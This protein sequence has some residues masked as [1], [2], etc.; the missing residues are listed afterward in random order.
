MWAEDIVSRAA[1]VTVFSRSQPWRHPLEEDWLGRVGSRA[2][3]KVRKSHISTLDGWFEQQCLVSPKSPV[4]CHR[5]E[6]F[7]AGDVEPGPARVLY[8]GDGAL[9]SLCWACSFVC[10]KPLR[11]D[12]MVWPP[13]LVRE[14]LLWHFLDNRGPAAAQK[15]SPVKAHR[16]WLTSWSLVMC[17]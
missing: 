5:P 13:C 8:R 14:E 12:W 2:Q 17:F 6:M 11:L 16:C 1:G 9:L 10:F 15:P 3:L 4:F 7:C